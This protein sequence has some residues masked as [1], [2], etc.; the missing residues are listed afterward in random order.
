MFAKDQALQYLAQGIKQSAVAGALGV[1]ESY[2]SQLLDDEDFKNELAEAKS[3]LSLKDANYDEK[4]D[5][6]TEAALDKI[7]AKLPYA[8]LQQSLQ[9]FRVLDG[10]KRRRDKGVAAV[11]E[12]VGVIVNILLPTAIVPRYLQNQAGEIVEVEGQTMV[13]ATPKNLEDLIAKR[14]ELKLDPNTSAA[15]V[16]EVEKLKDQLQ[17]AGREHAADFLPRI[18]PVKKS[19][20]KI[21]LL[22]SEDL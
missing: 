18:A 14:K 10:A 17:V 22:T 7:D 12:G 6:A 8:N 9:A 16:L 5:R 1:E 13:S 15:R 3:K 4:L 20:R 11:G 21:G 19:V 2:I